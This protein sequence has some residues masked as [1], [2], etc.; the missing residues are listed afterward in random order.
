M[1]I[2]EIVLCGQRIAISELSNRHLH[3]LPTPSPSSSSILTSRR[4]SRSASNP[5]PSIHLHKTTWRLRSFQ[6]MV[7]FATNMMEPC[8]NPM[9]PRSLSRRSPPLRFPIYRSNPGLCSVRSSRQVMLGILSPRRDTFCQTH[10]WPKCPI[11][12][13]CRLTLLQDQGQKGQMDRMRV[14]LHH[15]SRCT[16]G[17]H[18]YLQTIQQEQ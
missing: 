12:Q 17:Q 8:S 10:P 15:C 7:N 14:R 9:R 4:R 6:F 2:A 1:Q 18:K 16:R 13:G 5:V 11:R 3:H